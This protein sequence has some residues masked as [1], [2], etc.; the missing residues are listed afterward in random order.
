MIKSISN[1]LL[2]ALIL[3]PLFFTTS[4]LKKGDEDPGI[5]LRCRKARLTGTWNLTELKEDYSYSY[6]NPP[7][8]EFTDL[9]TVKYEDLWLTTLENG[10]LNR[11]LIQRY[12]YESGDQFTYTTTESGGITR[13]ILDS[14][15]AGIVSSTEISTGTY[16]SQHSQ[17]ITINSDGT[18]TLTR[19]NNRTS[20]LKTDYVSYE[21]SDEERIESYRVTYDGTWGFLGK[22]KIN[23]FKNKERVGFW[24]SSSTRIIEGH[25]NSVYTDKDSTDGIDYSDLGGY[26]ETNENETNYPAN[27]NPDF[28]WEIIRLSNK[29]IKLTMTSSS[30]LNTVSES[31]MRDY[32]G[33]DLYEYQQ[34]IDR[35]NSINTEM[36]LTQD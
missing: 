20:N 24:I 31:L 1:L 27:S 4:C 6:T 32:L 3:C 19:L 22:Q 21:I 34:S 12:T 2:G 8:N 25:S 33:N 14:N 16:V 36:T 13:T 15:Y 29:E 26:S 35:T 10:S 7:S 9:E 23:D 17:S 18:F 28:V 11:D 5:S 30:E